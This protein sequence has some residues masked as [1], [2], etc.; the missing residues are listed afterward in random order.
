MPGFRLRAFMLVMVLL[1]SVSAFSQQTP[2]P[3]TGARPLFK[4]FMAINGHFTFKP[5]LYRPVAGLVRNYHNV[6]W[7]VK[8]PGDPITFP[9]CVNKVDWKRDVYARWQKAGFETDICIQFSGFEAGNANYQKLW[10]GKE[11]WCFD[12]GK[13][14]AAFCGPSGA[15]KLCTSIE[16]GNEPGAK[17]DAALYKSIFKKMAAGIRAGDPRVKILTANS[18]ARDG[19]NFTQDL[20]RM[21]GDADMLPLY[22]AINIHTYA[23]V[24]RKNNSQSPWNRSYPEDE[25]ISYLKVVDEAIDW[26]DKNAKGKEVWITEFGYDA[27]TP[28]AMKRRTDWFQK[29]DWQGTT[30]LQQAQY[31][32]RSFIAFAERDV[33]RAYIYY[34][35]DKD[36]PS[37]HGA[38]GLTRNFAPKMSYWAVKQLQQI[39]GD[40][41]FSR[42]IKKQKGE[43]FVYEFTHGTDPGRV[44]WVAWSPTGARTNEKDTYVPHEARVTLTDLPGLPEQVVGMA[45]ADGPAPKAAWDKA[46][47]TSLSLTVTESP[48]YIV[49]LRAGTK[50][51]PK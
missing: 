42:V 7:D 46:G 36:S 14:I 2:S 12:Y 10:A 39:L 40:Y 50:T 3:A 33:R 43:V 45:T 5:D 25:S 15:E 51:A 21:Y 6:N 41:R 1:A 19:D 9:V 23:A 30:D 32:V 27:C 29:L 49:M 20:R 8:Q 48:T 4:D 17:F 47:D 18:H 16:I 44:I 26:R 38:A 31:L 22:D 28:E 24:D 34:Y 11:Q 35:D 37:V 13:A